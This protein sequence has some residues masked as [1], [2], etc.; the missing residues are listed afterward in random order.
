M[1]CQIVYRATGVGQLSK[2]SFKPLLS[3]GIHYNWE[4]M[5]KEAI[6]FKTPKTVNCPLFCITKAAL[7]KKSKRYEREQNMGFEKK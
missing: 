5:Y 7:P 6:P 2:D 3:S 4:W 1:V